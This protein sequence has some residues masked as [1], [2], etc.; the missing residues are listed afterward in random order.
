[1][2]HW[3][4]AVL[5]LF[6]AANAT[7]QALDQP[8]ATIKLEK[9]SSLVTQSA[10]RQRVAAIEAQRSM[11]L[12][13]AAKSQLLQEMVTEELIHMDQEAKGIK[14]TDEDLLKQFRASN[15]GFTDAQIRA[16]VEKQSGKSWDEAVVPLK[17]QVTNMKYFNQFP[18][19][20]ELGKITVSDAE[21]KDFFD[22]NTAMF[23]APEY[24]RVSHI[25]FDTKQKPKGTLDEIKK[26]AD[27][28]L[29]LITSGQKTFE[30]VA[31]S[32]S[33]DPGSAKSNGDIGY[34]PRNFDSQVGQ[35]LV[36][37]FGRSFLDAVFALKKGDVSGVMT[38]N[39]GLHIV[40]VTQTIDKHF[41]TLDEPVYPGKDETVR[42]YIQQSLQQRKLVAAQTKMINEIG[43]DL[44]TKAT[45][46][47]FEQNF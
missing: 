31:A 8:V 39:A 7:G 26:R 40:R 30:E 38:S 12:D 35:R 41:M 3:G 37:I 19:A 5:A 25:F 13:A 36:Q 11:T 34:L 27:D 20:A 28:T 10:F 6:L 45:I 44:R 17:R 24:I 16:E 42:A 29:K 9:T 47:T 4:W 33:E 15:P 23:T 2:K 32:V 46:K 43:A 18:Q 21:I 14:A 1:M 22:S